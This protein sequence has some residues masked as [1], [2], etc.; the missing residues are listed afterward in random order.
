MGHVI[1]IFI[2]AVCRVPSC[3]RMY[4]AK[5]IHRK[6]ITFSKH[7]QNV[8]CSNIWPNIDAYTYKLIGSY[9]L[10]KHIN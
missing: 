10:G 7:Q 6:Y 3:C 9:S 2:G 4:F 1:T 8:I 5:Y